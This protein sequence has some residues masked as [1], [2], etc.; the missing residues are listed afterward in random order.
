MNNIKTLR[1]SANIT[2]KKLA[3]ASGF[4]SAQTLI[5]NYESEYRSLKIDTGHMIVM[6]FNSL[7]VNCNFLDVFPPIPL[8]KAS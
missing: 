7:G 2:Q 5:S 3:L 1:E 4:G 6:G 8:K